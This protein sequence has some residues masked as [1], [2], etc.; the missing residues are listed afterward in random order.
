MAK[1]KKE[2]RFIEVDSQSLGT[3][4][5]Y[6]D[7]TTGVNYACTTGAFSPLYDAFGNILVTSI[8]TE[9]E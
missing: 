4:V 8:P 9:D 1:R 2:P 6:V 3:L 5:V 7:R